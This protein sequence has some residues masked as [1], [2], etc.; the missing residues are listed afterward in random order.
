MWELGMKVSR[1]IALSLGLP[2]NYF[3]KEGVFDK[4]CVLLRL[5]HYFPVISDPSKKI[6]AASPHTDY[7]MLALLTTDGS[8]GL[9]IETDGEWN[10]VPHIEGAIIVNIGDM[11]QKWT[12]GRYKST[13]HRV[14]LRESVDRYSAAFFFEPNVKCVVKNILSV[15]NKNEETATVFGA[16]LTKKIQEAENS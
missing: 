9:Q 5:I 12:G 8:P 6:Y 14:I 11:L 3:D 13:N 16:H 10:D 4:P 1:I 2:T 15:P 7:G